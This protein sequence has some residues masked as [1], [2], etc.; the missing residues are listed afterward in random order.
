MKLNPKGYVPTMLV[1]TDNKPICESA[2]IIEYID[3]KFQGKSKLLGEI[4]A[5]PIF[6]ERYE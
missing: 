3:S 4:E 5:D 6:K 2:N 1:G